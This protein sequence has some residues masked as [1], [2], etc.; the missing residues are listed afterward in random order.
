MNEIKNIGGITPP[1]KTT[2]QSDS[3]NTERFEKALKVEPSESI[4]KRDKRNRSKKQEDLE[5]D[6]NESSLSIAVPPGVFKEKMA[7]SDKTSSV[8][9]AGEGTKANLSVTSNSSK[10]STQSV[11]T[12]SVEDGQKSNISVGA[13]NSASEEENNPTPSTPSL[14]TNSSQALTQPYQPTEPTIEFS[15]PNNPSP[16]SSQPSN[17]STTESTTTTKK[18]KTPSKIEKKEKLSSLKTPKKE[19]NSS[20]QA[21]EKKDAAKIVSAPLKQASN[22]DISGK[23]GSIVSDTMLKKNNPTIIKD[24][25]DDKEVS[26]AISREMGDSQKDSNNNQE[27]NAN[28]SISVPLTPPPGI[29]ALE[30]SPFANIPKDVFDL[31]QKMV[32]MM[33]VQKNSLKSVT[34]ITL[35]MPNSVFNKS[36][37]VL[38]QYSTAPHS[39]NVQLFGSPQAIERFAKNMQG[40]NQSIKDSKLTFSIN[41]LPPKLS[42][43]FVGRIGSTNPDKEEQEEKDGEESN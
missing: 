5:D 31:Y 18:A 10:A 19:S 12:G 41:V 21:E 38:E 15:S 25:E 42:K 37:L 14:N 26:I 17:S 34:T 3:V 24:K 39:F 35:N 6:E 29:T 8:F 16:V 20:P 30:M 13:S 32:G 11:Y 27:G 2:I 33:T 9:D 23:L 43:N 40:L 22:D 28:A 36:Q 4:D 7:E 1:L